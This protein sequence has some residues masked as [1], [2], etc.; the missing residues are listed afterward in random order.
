M[1]KKKYTGKRLFPFEQGRLQ[2]LF[3]PDDDYVTEYCTIL[4]RKEYICRQLKVEGFRL[5]FGLDYRNGRPRIWTP[6]NDKVSDYVY[7]YP[8]ES[9]KGYKQLIQS[10]E[11]LNAKSDLPRGEWGNAGFEIEEDYKTSQEIWNQSMRLSNEKH[12]QGVQIINQSKTFSNP[13][14]L[15]RTLDDSLRFWMAAREK[16]AFIVNA[17]EWN[18]LL[19]SDEEKK[20]ENCYWDVLNRPRNK[21]LFLQVISP[22]GDWPVHYNKA[23]TLPLR[24]ECTTLHKVEPKE[25]SNKNRHF[26][27]W[28][29]QT[30]GISFVPSL[31]EENVEQMLKHKYLAEYPEYPMDFTIL[32]EAAKEIVYLRTQFVATD[33][34]EKMEG[35]NKGPEGKIRGMQTIEPIRDLNRYRFADI[36]EWREF[37]NYMKE[38]NPRYYSWAD[39]PLEQIDAMNQ[40]L[41]QNLFGQD[42]QIDQFCEALKMGIKEASKRANGNGEVKK[43]PPVVIFLAGPS[44]TGKSEMVRKAV[45]FLFGDCENRLHDKFNGNTVKG[46]H[47]LLGAEPGTKGYQDRNDFKEFLLQDICKIFLFDEIHSANEEVRRLFMQMMEKRTGKLA[48]SDQSIAY[49]NETVIVFTSNDGCQTPVEEKDIPEYDELYSIV[50]KSIHKSINDEA[51]MNRVDQFICFNY[52]TEQAVKGMALK[53]LDV[54]KQEY[55]NLFFDISDEKSTDVIKYLIAVGMPHRNKGA[56]NVMKAIEKAVDVVISTLDLEKVEQGYCLNVRNGILQLDYVK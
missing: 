17:R 12:P 30:G 41:K 18:E 26:E 47:V 21:E 5:I 46:L 38:R 37:E 45:E 29:E 51:W 8:E 7:K 28:A 22:H 39:I 24:W 36:E 35:L 3:M 40:F 34:K 27:N 43:G 20:L 9:S 42:L 56:E 10:I 23:L 4:N 2:F 50:M 6:E 48:F 44:R 14:K 19:E 25:T 31:T 32:N 49:F 52:L 15:I 33:N 54:K 1:P 55:S 11:K 16:V 53:V 13:S